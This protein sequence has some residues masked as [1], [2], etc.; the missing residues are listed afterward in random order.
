M[1]LVPCS[2]GEGRTRG[3]HESIE[4]G[5][6]NEQTLQIVLFSCRFVSLRGWPGTRAE[7]VLERTATL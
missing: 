4:P 2:R 5:K 6:M 3:I 7:N 1:V